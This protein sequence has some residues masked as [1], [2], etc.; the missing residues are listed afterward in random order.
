MEVIKWFMLAQRAFVTVITTA[1]HLLAPD[2][3]WGTVALS[4]LAEDRH[5][6]VVGRDLLIPTTSSTM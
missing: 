3:P 1:M 4:R 6:Q 2:F 5:H